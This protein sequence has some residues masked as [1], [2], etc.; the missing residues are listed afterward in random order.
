MG[1]PTTTFGGGGSG[2]TTPTVTI[3]GSGYVYIGHDSQVTQ[4]INGFFGTGTPSGGT[5]SWSSSDSSVSFDN[6]A[7]SHVHVTATS[8]SGGTN[9]T[10]ITLNYSANGQ[11]AT[12]ATVTVTKR[13]FYYLGNDSMVLYAT[14]NGPSTYGYTYYRYYNVFTHPDHGQVTDGNGIGATENVSQQSSNS[15][16]S[17]HFDNGS[18]DANSQ[19]QDLFQLVSSAP[20]PAT[21]SIVDSQDI[22]VGGFFVRNNTIT[23]TASGVTVN[24]NGPSN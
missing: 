4:S 21:L 5:Y 13:L 9:D 24:S 3:Q 23:F 22:G 12:P 20:L 15:N 16:V 17:P 7:A 6:N 11:S 14:Y 1:C 10:P 18:L 8:Y 19:L 2:T